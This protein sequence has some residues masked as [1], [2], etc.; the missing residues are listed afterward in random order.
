MKKIFIYLLS[1]YANLSVAFG[2]NI[3]SSYVAS[4]DS[5]S[6][7]YY[8]KP[9]VNITI[10]QISQNAE[11]LGFGSDFTFRLLRIDTF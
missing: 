6:H 1:F 10:S 11:G 4:Y 7:W 8:F 3:D 2:Q 9:G 5:A